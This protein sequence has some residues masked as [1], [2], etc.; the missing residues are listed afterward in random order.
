[1]INFTVDDS[2]P[3]TEDGNY[4]IYEKENPSVE[5]FSFT[6]TIG[7]FYS[8]Y[9]SNNTLIAKV[10]KDNIEYTATKIFTFG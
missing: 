7:S 6:Y 5:D 8:A 2:W 3:I 9:K 10:L 4:Y 1:M